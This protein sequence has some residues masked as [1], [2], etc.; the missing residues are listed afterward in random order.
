MMDTKGHGGARRGAGRRLASER[1]KVV[2][3]LLPLATLAK[4]LAE[5]TLRAGDINAFLTVEP[6]GPASVPLMGSTAACGFPSPAE[7]YL[8]RPLDFNELMIA[9]PAATFAVRVAGESMI[10]AGIFPN[11]IA[12]IDRSLAASNGL[13]VL[14]LLNGEFTI[15]RYRRNERRTW[16][17]PEN[18]GFRDI[19]LSDGI[20]FEVWG[21][22]TRS[23]RM[24]A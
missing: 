3:L 24:L 16:L 6:R 13:I 14:A 5:K 15:K 21:V 22:V 9:N 23:I 11:D 12:V 20:E 2:R 17:Q 8:D 19:D 1:T 18:A 10:G 7:D 4:R